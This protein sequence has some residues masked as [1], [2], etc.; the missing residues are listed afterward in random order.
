[1][2]IPEADLPKLFQQF[3]RASNVKKIAGTGLGLYIAK[4]FAEANAIEIEVDS[5]EDIGTTFSL[6]F[7]QTG[8]AQTQ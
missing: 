7:N 2:G 4:R 3:H 8:H 5:K 1:V 6:T